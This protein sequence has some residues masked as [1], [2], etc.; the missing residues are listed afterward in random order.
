[1]TRVLTTVPSIDR[2][3]VTEL[4]R[5]ERERNFTGWYAV[6][7]PD[8]CPCGRDMDYLRVG[9][10]RPHAGSILVWPARDDPNLLKVIEGY[11]R[12]RLKSTVVDYEHSMGPCVSWYSIPED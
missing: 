12:E 3:K 2:D 11:A 9:M 10:Y 8:G 4:L 6:T 1:M 5:K 7:H